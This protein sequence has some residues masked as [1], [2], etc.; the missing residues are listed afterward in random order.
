M[1]NHPHKLLICLP[2][3]LAAIINNT[4]AV[5]LFCLRELLVYRIP[6]S[7]LWNLDRNEKQSSFHVNGCFTCGLLTFLYC[8]G[9]VDNTLPSMTIGVV[10]TWS[11]ASLTKGDAA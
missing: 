3:P 11:S 8:I 1:S 2:I 5:N 10:E 7:E 4:P 6:S 9:G